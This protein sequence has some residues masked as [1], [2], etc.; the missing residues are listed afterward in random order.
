LQLLPEL[1]LLTRNSPMWQPAMAIQPHG[2]QEQLKLLQGLGSQISATH[3]K[4]HCS[5]PKILVM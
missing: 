1:Q 3:N 4:G 5:L 2:V